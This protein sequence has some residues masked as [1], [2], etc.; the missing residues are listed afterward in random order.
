MTD[1][2]FRRQQ[3]EQARQRQA[4]SV[5]APST[6]QGATT[7][8]LTPTNEAPPR[9]LYRS[10]RNR[11][12]AGVAGGIAEYL[13]VDPTL[14]RILLFLALLPTGPFGVFIYAVLAFTIPPTP[15][16]GERF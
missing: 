7:V 15:G 13:N 12:L 14:T 3:E 5:D 4:G 9:Q 16:G 1:D 6:G 11:V 8:R 2:Y 10:T